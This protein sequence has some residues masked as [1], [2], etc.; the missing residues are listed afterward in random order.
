MEDNLTL[1]NNA[2]RSSYCEHKD[3]IWEW[4]DIGEAAP[5]L[6][7]GECQDCNKLIET[8]D[9]TIEQIYELTRDEVADA[10]DRAYESARAYYE[11]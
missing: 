11:G 3:V 8:D 2:I 7:G 6:L 4:E 9:L 10:T 1:L 5:A